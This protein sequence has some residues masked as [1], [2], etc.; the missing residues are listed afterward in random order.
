MARNASPVGLKGQGGAAV[1]III[2]VVA[3]VAILF[4]F[5]GL[6]GGIFT[7][8]GSGAITGIGPGTA[9]V[10]ITSFIA[11]PAVTEGGE[12]VSFV[13]TAENRGGADADIQECDIFGLGDWSPSGGS[14]EES[15][16]STLAKAD[17]TRQTVGDTMV[18]EWS[19]T[20]PEKNTDITYPV[21][22][23]V[24]YRYTTEADIPLTIYGRNSPDVK[25]TGITQ[26]SMGQIA[27][28]G[29][30]INVVPRGTVPLIGSN[31]EFTISFDITNIGGGRPYSGTSSSG[32]DRVRIVDSDCENIDNGHEYRLIN[33][34]RTISCR[35]DSGISSDEKDVKVVHIEVEYNYIVESVTNVQVIKS[36]E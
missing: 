11:L 8:G 28:T 17:P 12:E 14:T 18:P 1:A 32:L 29:G 9:G 2:V 25:N 15:C 36:S 19:A 16:L 35:V 6:L 21:T 3:A 31:P 5:P 7:G 4:L 22:A 26:S 20:A 10:V 24:D 34:A 27:V 30:P 33:N 23:R 13:L